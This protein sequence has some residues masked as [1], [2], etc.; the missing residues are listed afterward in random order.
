MKEKESGNQKKEENSKCK[1]YTSIIQPTLT[2]V[3]LP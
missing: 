3:M 2:D 1:E